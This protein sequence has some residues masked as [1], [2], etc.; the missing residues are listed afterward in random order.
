MRSIKV[1]YSNGAGVYCVSHDVNVPFCLPELSHR[2]I[3]NHHFHVDNDK[4]DLGTSYDMIIG[5]DLMVYIGL[6]ADFNRQVL[7]WDDD[8]IH[9]KEPSSMLGKSDL[10]KREMRKLVMQTAEPA[11]N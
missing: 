3:T 7:Q 11:S 6:M 10:T 1:D 8:N 9:M 4:G 2:K 5:R